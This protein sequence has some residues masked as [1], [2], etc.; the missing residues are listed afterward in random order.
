MKFNEISDSEEVKVGQKVRLPSREILE[1]MKRTLPAS[2][3]K[4]AAKA[5]RTAPTPVTPPT[6]VS[7]P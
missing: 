5:P 2:P 7:P 3:R 1:K 4:G 6:P